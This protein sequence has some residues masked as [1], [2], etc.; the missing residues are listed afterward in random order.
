MSDA[1][2]PRSVIGI[3]GVPPFVLGWEKNTYAKNHNEMSEAR[4]R[5]EAEFKVIAAND[6]LQNYDAIKTIH[7]SLSAQDQRGRAKIHLAPIGTKPVA[8]AMCWFA[9]NHKGTGILYDFVKKKVKRSNGVGKV[10]FWS[11]VCQ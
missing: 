8:L 4:K 9:I 7:K 3:L 6:P 10:H 11:F 5:I 1:I 2:T